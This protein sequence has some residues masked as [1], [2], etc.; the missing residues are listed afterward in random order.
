MKQRHQ[1]RQR[2]QRRQRGASLVEAAIVIP[3]LLFIFLGVLQTAMVFYAKSNLNYATFEA[4]RAGSVNNADMAA[5]TAAFQKALVPYYG[6]GNTTAELTAKL[7][8][9]AQDINTNGAMRIEILSPTTESFSDFNSP[10]LQAQMRVTELVIPNVALDELSCPR[11]VPGCK[12]DSKTN[13]SGQSLADANLLKLRI[14]YGIPQTKQMPLAGR[15]YTWALKQ[16]GAAGADAFKLGLIQANRI[17]VV[18][19]TTL[20]MQSN[21]VRNAAM[22][23]SPGQGNAGVATDPGPLAGGGGLPSCAWWDPSCAICSSGATGDCGGGGGGGG[24]GT[25]PPANR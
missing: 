5:I 14:T 17:P 25:C 22:V 7:A 16:T 9:V 1:L 6:G 15:F 18:T 11:D 8:Q 3:L 2:R 23:S 19:H 21:A 20:R 4:A 12:S 13:S 10:A 24:G